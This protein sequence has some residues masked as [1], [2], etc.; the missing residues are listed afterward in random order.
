MTAQRV[1]ERPAR[2]T[3]RPRPAKRRGT[4]LSWGVMALVLFAA[5]AV[6]ALRDGPAQTNADRARDLGDTI[7]CPTCRSQSVA[8]SDAP[9]AGEIRA[10]IARRI[11]GGQSDEEIRGFLVG[12]YGEEILLTPAAS[13]VSAL[14]WVLPV[15]GVVAAGAGLVVAFRRWRRE[16]APE[17][18]D[19]DRE[20]VARS[21]ADRETES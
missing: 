10:E 17:A 20:I 2:P 18:S 5:L 14:V 15:V 12:R 8:D 21:L 6:G 9:I 1:E 4:W 13:G 16:E 7:K 3:S 11:E 19:A